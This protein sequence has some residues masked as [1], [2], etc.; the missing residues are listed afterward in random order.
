[1]SQTA[2]HNIMLTVA[3]LTFSCSVRVRVRALAPLSP[4][5]A[6]ERIVTGV[7]LR[8][9][10][11][12]GTPRGRLRTLGAR[13]LYYVSDSPCEEHRS[14]LLCIVYKHHG[15]FSHQGLV[16]VERNSAKS[17]GTACVSIRSQ[18]KYVGR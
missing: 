2:R 15:H 4:K 16:A 11:T 18:Q 10:W 9:A 1:M 7:Y 13:K 12:V 17:E 8:R 5:V 14:T 3:S 6:C